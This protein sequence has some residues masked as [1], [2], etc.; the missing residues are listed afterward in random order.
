M[1]K[2]LHNTWSHPKLAW[3][4]GR[5]QMHRPC[6]SASL[7][8]WTSMQVTCSSHTQ[9]STKMCTVAKLQ[10]DQTIKPMVVVRRQP[11]YESTKKGAPRTESQAKMID[12]PETQAAMA[13]HHSTPR[14]TI[15]SPQATCLNSCLKRAP[16][17][18]CIPLKTSTAT[19]SI[20]RIWIQ[21]WRAFLRQMWD[22]S[23]K[24]PNL[25]PPKAPSLSVRRTWTKRTTSLKKWLLKMKQRTCGEVSSEVMARLT[26][27]WWAIAITVAPLH[28]D[29]A[30][31]LW[32]RK[33][34]QASGRPIEENNLSAWTGTPIHRHP[35]ATATK[36]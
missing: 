5:E 27:K 35:S 16:M 2:T 14:L 3:S 17:E 26:F 6:S 19:K 33:A 18:V 23:T 1:S 4:Q 28:L 7:R 13:V 34:L 29:A 10:N 24:S 25:V 9:S 20:W 31:R 21:I 15:S 12:N 32:Q 8:I 36:W 11:L 22:S 30:T